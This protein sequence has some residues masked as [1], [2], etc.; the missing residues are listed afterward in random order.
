MNIIT[1]HLALPGYGRNL[2]RQAAR[3]V[4]TIFS[5]PEPMDRIA[6]RTTEGHDDFPKVSV[7]VRPQAPRAEFTEKFIEQVRSRK[8]ESP[9]TFLSSPLPKREQSHDMAEAMRLNPGYGVVLDPGELKVDGWSKADYVSHWSDVREAFSDEMQ[10]VMGPGWEQSQECLVAASHAK[11]LGIP[12]MQLKARPLSRMDI[13][14][15]LTESEQ[16]LKARGFEPPNFVDTLNGAVDQKYLEDK[17][18]GDFTTDQQLK[19]PEKYVFDV[20]ARTLNG[21]DDVENDGAKQA[22]K[23]SQPEFTRLYVESAKEQLDGQPMTY[24]STPIT[25]GSRKYDLYRDLGVKDKSEFDQTGKKRFVKDV[26]VANT[27]VAFRIAESVRSE[28]GYGMVMDPSEITIPEWSQSH[29]AAH[30]DAVVKELASKVVLAP[31]W[32]FSSGCILELKR[33]LDKGVPVEEVALM[34]VSSSELEG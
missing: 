29:Y 25:G 14:M 4:R 22:G 33:A 28:Q 18:T 21:R 27:N 5:S 20:V 13:E 1:N 7:K 6:L 24:I 8:G 12:T 32:D 15:R 19:N 10:M 3:D 31:G 9:L 16:E 11:S 30:W 17:A 26:I 2:A 23:L 34:P